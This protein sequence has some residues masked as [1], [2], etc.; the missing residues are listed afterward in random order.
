M[1]VVTRVLVAATLVFGLGCA[2]TDW[3]DRTLLTETVAGAWTGSM[4]T[5]GGQPMISQEVRLELQQ[6]GP[7]VIGSFR[8]TYG[9]DLRGSLPLE[10]SV[11]GDV[12]TFK[13]ERGSISGELTVSGD[14]MRGRG[15]VGSNRPVTFSL[16]RVDD[17]SPP[18]T[19]PTQ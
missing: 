11:A 6:K 3:I 17:A 5:P 13:D 19:A 4:V 12:F 8:G 15:I 18:S 2:K 7:K 10:G 9:A 14:E 16:R 1:R